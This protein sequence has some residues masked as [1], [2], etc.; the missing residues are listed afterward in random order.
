M[1]FLQVASLRQV[2]ALSLVTVTAVSGSSLWVTP[3][4]ALTAATSF[5]C[6]KV[7]GKPATV[8]RTKKGDIPIV[9]WSSADMS[10]SG[11]TPQVRC[12]QVSA[13]F[14]S[15]YRS[16]QLKHMTAGIL[17]KQPVVCATKQLDG[18]CTPQNLLYTLKPNADP[19]LAIKKLSAIRNR[20]S[21]NVLEE[22]AGISATTATNSIDLDW[23]DEEN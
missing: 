9:V 19:R 7:D 10:E 3:S 11:Y 13:R 20:A 5:V 8:A 12:Q 22:S 15:M 18:P 14:Q 21:S 1:K 16:G 6:G 23:L 17:N 2:V 4:Q